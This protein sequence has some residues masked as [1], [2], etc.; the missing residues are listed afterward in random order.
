M[1][2]RTKLIETLIYQKGY[3]IKSFSEYINVPYTTILTM[4][5]RG[6]GGTAVDTIIKVCEALGVSVDALTRKHFDNIL[7]PEL[8]T[9]LDNAKHLSPE[10]LTKLNEFIDTLKKS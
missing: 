1:D 2:E 6:I 9:L 5:K 10:Q 8:Q 3:N 7:T 4:L